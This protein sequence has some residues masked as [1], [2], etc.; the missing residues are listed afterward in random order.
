MYVR[1]S[2]G[3]Q[4][5]ETQNDAVVRAARARGDVIGRVYAEIEGGGAR[6]RPELERLLED[7]RAG[8]IGRLYVYRLDRLSR[9]GIRSMLALVEELEAGGVEL[10]TI[11]DGFTLAG[12]ARDVILSVVAWAAQMERQAIGERISA[13]RTRVLAEGGQ[14]GRP[15]REVDARQIAARRSR[16]ESIRQIAQALHVPK[17]TVHRV[18]GHVAVADSIAVPKTLVKTGPSELR[19]T[20]AKK[21]RPG[22]SQ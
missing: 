21:G 10:I 18:L 2:T 4:S 13:A 5:V 17:S 20:R 14:W 3:G 19:K 9:A 22:S 12:P 1:V 15:R 6:R 11:A 7:V 16:G 8:L